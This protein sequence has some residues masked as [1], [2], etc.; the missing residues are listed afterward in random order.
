MP[1]H[2]PGWRLEGVALALRMP[3][4]L[5]REARLFD[6]K[7]M[8]RNA[9]NLSKARLPGELAVVGQFH[10]GRNGA[11]VALPLLPCCHH[12]SALGF[13]QAVFALC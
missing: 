10:E 11:G 1:L 6:Q 8:E 9:E 4:Q 3:A 5:E 12:A 7:V 2:L 13:N